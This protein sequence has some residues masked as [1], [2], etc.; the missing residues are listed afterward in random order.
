[1]MDFE[2]ARQTA[3]DW[4]GGGGSPLYAWASTGGKLISYT[5]DETRAEV[6]KCLEWAEEND[7]SE[8]QR[9]ENLHDFL[10]MEAQEWSEYMISEFGNE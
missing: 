7:P 5:A 10:L 4:H 2:T 9:L 8:V 1:M 6:V 3:Y